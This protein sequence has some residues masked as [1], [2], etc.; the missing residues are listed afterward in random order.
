MT[1]TQTD[2]TVIIASITTFLAFLLNAKLGSVWLLYLNVIVVVGVFGYA[3]RPWDRLSHLSRSAICG[4]IA[5]ITYI[6]LDWLFSRR[7][8]LL[9]YLSSGD[10]RIAAV[11]LSLLL[12]WM[13][14]I[15]I[16]VY[17]YH[18][19]NAIWEQPY[20]PAVIVGSLAFVGST[21][22]DQLG[23]ARLW[24]WKRNALFLFPLYRF[25]SYLRS[26]STCPDLFTVPV[27]SP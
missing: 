14:V 13:I 16:I 7:V 11:P 6:P 5:S 1:I 8:A 27:L 18:R 9:S 10:I 3:S 12:T 23:S 25:R 19:F 2:K 17:I 26:D 20:I 22:F 24:N 4:V 15:T 21:I